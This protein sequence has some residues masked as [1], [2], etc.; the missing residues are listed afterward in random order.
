MITSDPQRF[1]EPSPAEAPT[2]SPQSIPMFISH[3]RHS[4]PVD[5]RSFALL[6]WVCLPTPE[7]NGLLWLILSIGVTSPT[8]EYL[9]RRL[10]ASA[11][12]TPFIG[13]AAAN[14]W[15]RRLT[16]AVIGRRS[17]PTSLFFG[18]LAFL[19]LL[20][21]S[22]RRWKR[23][24]QPSGG[25]PPSGTVCAICLER[26]DRSS[27]P[28]SPTSP[29]SPR[30][31]EGEEWQTL[32]CGHWFHVSC[33]QQWLRTKNSC[34][35]CRKVDPMSMDTADVA[36]LSA[37]QLKPLWDLKPW[38]G[39]L[40]LIFVLYERARLARVGNGRVVVFDLVRMLLRVL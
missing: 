5:L 2:H 37:F 36:E 6:T 35:Y 14:H 9:G 27:A 25:V 1:P 3:L 29:D 32:G 28:T 13:T 11:K 21:F 4:A 7:E 17:L 20:I 12:L 31:H 16:A 18:L 30:I 39:I 34:P 23:W 10:C 15:S 19:T 33:C 40:P 24:S 26:S 38:T 8:G 22:H